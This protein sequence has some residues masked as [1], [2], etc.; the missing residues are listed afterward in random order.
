MITLQGIH[1]FL[2]G[3]IPGQLII[4]FSNRCNA[5]CPQC[6]MR[7]SARIDRNTLSRKRVLQLIDD[8]A[9]KGY[10][11]LSLTGGEPLM[12]LDDLL[13]YI[14]HAN[15]AGIPHIRTGTN[16][17]IFQGS[18]KPGFEQRIHRI[19][20]GLERSGVSSF[21]V[22]LDSASPQ[23]HE[24]MRGLP[25]VIEGIKKGLPIF[26]AHN[27]YPSANIGINR[28]TGGKNDLLYQDTLE[29]D[30]FF[31]LFKEAFAKFYE[32]AVELGFTT[33][34]ACY[35]M[36]QDEDQSSVNP[37]QETGGG[38]VSTYGA[39]SSDK[40]IR[41]SPLEKGLIFQALLETI[42]KYRSQLRIFT[43]L[44]SLYNLVRQYRDG[45]ESLYSCHG[46]KDFFFVECNQGKI[47]PCGYL[48]EVFQELPDL[49]RR[50]NKKCDCNKCEWECFRDPSDLMGPFAELRS[51]PL[52][53]LGKF[54]NNREYYKLLSRDL[55]YYKA[56][57]YFDGKLPPNYENLRKFS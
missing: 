30:I 18:D 37:Q 27:I 10:Q 19:A 14:G 56:C 4:Q 45:K 50:S 16:G 57:N 20:E 23:A 11:A 36:S 9:G 25:G 46:G 1:P 43:P 54:F 6:G 31:Q 47:H 41:F 13:D 55:R 40:V 7:R 49:Q 28:N 48:D 39:I 22:S 29:P 15:Q 12:Y 44:C 17:F 32:F 21:W 24:D 38:S 35:P 26:H 34:S 33:A 42:P 53:L 51:S 52:G 8:A 2:K 5:D 3:R